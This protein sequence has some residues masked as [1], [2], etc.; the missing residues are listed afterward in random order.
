MEAALVRMIWIRATHRCEYCRI[1]QDYDDATFEID[2]VIARK[3][4]GQSVPSNLALS[5]LHCNSYKGSDIASRTSSHRKLT[6]LFHPRRMK[7]EK[8]F[9]WDGP[10][11]V[12]RTDIGRVTVRVLNINDPYRVELRRGLIEEGLFP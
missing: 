5:C 2:H 11:I 7:W 6:P 8:H 9:R 10:L 4:E 3:H 1:H 12:G